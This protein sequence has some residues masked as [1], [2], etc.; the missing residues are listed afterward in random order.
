MYTRIFRLFNKN[1]LFYSL[2]FGFRQNYS[3]THALFSLTGNIRKYLNEGH[4]VCGIFPDLQK[5]F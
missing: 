2:Q 4:F 5:S 1:N 3:T